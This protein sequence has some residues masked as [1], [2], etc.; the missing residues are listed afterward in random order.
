MQPKGFQGGRAPHFA[1]RNSGDSESPEFRSSPAARAAPWNRLGT[2]RCPSSQQRGHGGR[3]F[4]AKKSK[5]RTPNQMCA[6]FSKGPPSFS[7]AGKRDPADHH[8]SGQKALPAPSAT[9]TVPGLLS[10]FLACRCLTKFFL[11][12]MVGDKIALAQ[13]NVVTCP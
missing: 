6:E 4:P 3:L 2:E 10:L 9:R 12:R 8:S 5:I 11:G 1:Y 13:Q 7:R